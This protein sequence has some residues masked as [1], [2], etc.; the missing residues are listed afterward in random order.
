MEVR[1]NLRGLD[2]EKVP[3]ACRLPVKRQHGLF[4]L[5]IAKVLADENVPVVAH[6]HGILEM[7]SHGEEVGH[8]L[9]EADRERGISSCA[10][11]HQLAP[12]NDADHRIVDV[13][14]DWS[15]MNKERIRD[16]AEPRQRFA[17]ID[18]N[19][20]IGDVSACCDDGEAEFPEQD[21]MKGS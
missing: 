15:V 9:M 19:G 12:Q 4:C 17:L 20:F 8:A 10:A 3:Q 14:V 13:P 1:Y 5:E 2:A 18:A 11:H 7:G 6:R 21:V 16:A